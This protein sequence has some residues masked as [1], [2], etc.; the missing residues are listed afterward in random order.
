MLWNLQ[1]NNYTVQVISLVD[2]LDVEIFIQV[3][4]TVL[5]VPVYSINSASSSPI[6]LQFV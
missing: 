5:H 1:I 2:M 6:W 4:Y 3:I